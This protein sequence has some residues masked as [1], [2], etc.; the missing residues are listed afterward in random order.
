M[1]E[2]TAHHFGT[3]S[4]LPSWRRS[5]RTRR[6][7]KDRIPGAEHERLRR[8]VHSDDSGRAARPLR[9]PGGT[10]LQLPR[11]RMA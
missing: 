2:Q 4:L 9:D 3:Q 11:R 6:D 5:S 10:A 7:P 8:A 1:K